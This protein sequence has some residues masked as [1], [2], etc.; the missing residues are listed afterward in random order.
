MAAEFGRKEEAN[1]FGERQWHGTQPIDEG[2]RSELELTDEDRA[3]LLQVGIR[4]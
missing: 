2:N 4:P 3:F 1:G